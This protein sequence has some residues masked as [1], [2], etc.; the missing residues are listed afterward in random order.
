MGRAASTEPQCLY[1]GAFYL[2]FVPITH[3][4]EHEA[5][6][7]QKR[8]AI[9][10]LTR[11]SVQYYSQENTIVKLSQIYKNYIYQG[12]EILLLVKNT[13]GTL[14]LFNTEKRPDF[15]VTSRIQVSNNVYS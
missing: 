4:Y 6:L 12:G 11:L 9:Y 3:S 15:H 5:N 7:K 8:F 13:H 2:Y 1:K 14:H 10:V